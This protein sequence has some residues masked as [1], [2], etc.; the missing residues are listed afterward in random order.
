M[1]SSAAGRIKPRQRRAVQ[2]RCMAQGGYFE[3]TSTRCGIKQLGKGSFKQRSQLKLERDAGLR[4]R[5]QAG[6]VPAELSLL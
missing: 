3:T 2:I 6:W 1:W 5:G 4:S